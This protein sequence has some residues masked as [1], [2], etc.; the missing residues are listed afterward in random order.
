[1]SISY[2]AAIRAVE[3]AAITLTTFNG[4][5]AALVLL[6]VLL[7]NY[8]HRKSWLRI[9]YDRRVPF[10]LSIAILGSYIVFAVRE[11]SQLGSGIPTPGDAKSP[12]PSCVALNESSWWGRELW[13]PFI[14]PLAIWLPQVAL[15][16]RAVMMAGP[17][18][19]R[20]RFI[21][22]SA[23]NS[24]IF[25]R[26]GARLCIL[27]WWES[28]RWFSGSRLISSPRLP[29][30]PSSWSSQQTPTPHSV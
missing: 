4:V 24:T 14:L 20:V 13:P 3:I 12:S 29:A 21:V 2:E 6:L 30:V 23:E 5:S 16:V 28:F 9:S 7:D 26:F 25:P 8:R 19:F 1:M 10:Y 18:I 27:L 17:I 22:E 15:A 11:F